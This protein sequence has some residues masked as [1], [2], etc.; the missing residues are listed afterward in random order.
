MDKSAGHNAVRQLLSYSVQI[1]LRCWSSR[2]K[3][4]IT[5]RDIMCRYTRD[6]GFLD[7]GRS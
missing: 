1:Y 4:S 2:L 6:A 7:H 5:V 3:M